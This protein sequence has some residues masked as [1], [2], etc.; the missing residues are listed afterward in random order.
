MVPEGWVATTLGELVRIRGGKAPASLDTRDY[1][2]IPYLK[3][4]DLNNSTK[5]QSRS[6][7]YVEQ[8]SKPVAAN[9]IL[10]PKRGAAI[11][12]NKVRIA[13]VPNIIDSNMMALEV[14]GDKADYEFL[15]YKILDEGLYRIADT[16]TIPQINNKHINPYPVN[17]PPLP[18]QKKISEILSTWDKA[19]ETTE[20]LLANAEAQKKA[21]M[22]QLLTGKRRLKGFQGEWREFRLGQVFSERAERGGD[23]LPLL[24]ITSGRGV[25]YQSETDRRDTS[26]EDKSSYKRIREGDIGYN[27]MRMWQGVSALSRLDGLVSPAY[28]IVVPSASIHARFAAHLFRLPSQVHKFRRFSQGLTSDTWNLK[29][30][31]FAEVP[32]LIPTFSEQEAIAEVLD[33]CDF[34]IRNA[35]RTCEKLRSEKRGLMQQLLTGKRRVR[36]A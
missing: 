12:G 8:A 11:S 23:D 21:L 3:V 28:T 9:A 13:E 20:K 6:R 26:R 2:P 17:L 25:I 10:F 35:R 5:Y 14:D 19:I 36:V 31:Q 27:T 24:S 18:E 34:E 22:Q 15:Y 33:H 30:R 16:S 32:A 1:G 29:Y 7:N 4:E